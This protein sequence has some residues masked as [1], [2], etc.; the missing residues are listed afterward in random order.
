LNITRFL[1][2][3]SLSFW[4]AVAYLLVLIVGLLDYLTGPEVAVSILYLLPVSLTTWIGGWR[5]GLLVS[6]VSAA[7]GLSSNLPWELSHLPPAVP[8]WNAVVLLGTFV[9]VTF[10]VFELRGS[11]ER[12]ARIARMDFLTGVSNSRLFYEQANAEILRSR[13]YS[14]PLSLVYI[15]LDDFKMINDRFGHIQGDAL[16]RRAAETLRQTT[17]ETDLVARLGGEEFAALLPETGPKEAEFVARK[18]QASLFEAMR[19]DD[20]PVTASIGAVT[21]LK[22]PESVDQMVHEADHLMYAVKTN[23]KNGVLH[24]VSQG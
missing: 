13:R 4:T 15:D 22:P 18:I 14:R 5:R 20:C 11:L 23:G 2:R 12:E 7:V 3:R 21:F 17:R 10:L 6:A 19:D 1:N 9:V 16:L 24:A 8:F